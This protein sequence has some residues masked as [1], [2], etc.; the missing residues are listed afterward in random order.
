MRKENEKILYAKVQ[1]FNQETHLFGTPNQAYQLASNS[2][3]F[4]ALGI[5]LLSQQGKL[6]LDAPTDFYTKQLRFCGKCGAR[7]PVTIHQL[8]NHRGG[9]GWN[10]IRFQ[11]E[12]NLSLADTAQGIVSMSLKTKP[13]TKFCYATG[14]Y[15]VLGRL[16]EIISCQSY[17][18][19]MQRN[20]FTPLGLDRT[21]IEQPPLQGLREGLLGL[22]YTTWKGCEGF[23]PAGYLMSTPEN[24]ARWLELLLES[25][26]IE[27]E[28]KTLL[29]RS[30]NLHYYT[31]T[32]QQG[33]LYGFGWYYDEERNLYFHNGRNPCFSSCIA[34]SPTGRA[35]AAMC[36]IHSIRPGQYVFQFMDGKQ[37]EKISYTLWPITAKIGLGL[38][39]LGCFLVVREV[40]IAAVFL[41]PATTFVAQY[42]FY[43]ISGGLSVQQQYLWLPEW[44]FVLLWILPAGGIILVIG[45]LKIIFQ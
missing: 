10:T 36:N 42:V 33:I 35:A 17:G 31:E 6:D 28:Y 44:L 34:F 37:Q 13:G 30:R 25:A 21:G 5:L 8:L 45:I 24:C 20:I 32:E 3:A 1:H 38:L 15:V 27:D 14:G 7:L 23:A 29:Q 43:F 19:F 16:I 18:D 41:I 40:G 39:L 4:T 22:R 12:G 2:K 26:Q 9:L 11:H